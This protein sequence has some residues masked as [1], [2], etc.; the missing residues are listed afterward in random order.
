MG[1]RRVVRVVLSVVGEEHSEHVSR[2]LRSTAVVASLEELP[3]TVI[4]LL[5]LNEGGYVTDFRGEG[6]SNKSQ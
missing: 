6:H 3:P 5:T 2:V 1:W 4:A